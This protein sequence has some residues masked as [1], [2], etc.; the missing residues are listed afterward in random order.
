M[1]KRASALWELASNAEISRT[2]LT[3][4]FYNVYAS[5]YLEESTHTNPFPPAGIISKCTVLRLIFGHLTDEK[6]FCRGP[7]L[8]LFH[9]GC[10]KWQLG[11]NG[12]ARERA[13][14]YVTASYECGGDES[15]HQR[16]TAAVDAVV[17][18]KERLRAQLLLPPTTSTTK[19]SA[20]STTSK[21][22]FTGFLYCD[23]IVPRKRPVFVWS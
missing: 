1:H 11:E 9:R 14:T 18:L 10:R 8:W 6:G 16:R 4:C 17:G 20:S 22:G 12:N 15:R 2:F 3:M 7:T 19:V 5:P 21:L 23:G 13:M